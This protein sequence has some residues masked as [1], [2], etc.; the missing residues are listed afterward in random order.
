LVGPTFSCIIA[1]EFQNLKKG[2]RFYYENFKNQRVGTDVTAFTLGDFFFN[3]QIVIFFKIYNLNYR[4][5]ERDKK[6]Q[7]V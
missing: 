3:Q 7:D 6:S 4:S 5:I 2:D 1:R